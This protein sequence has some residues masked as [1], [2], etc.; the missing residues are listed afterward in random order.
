MDDL[1]PTLNVD[2][3]GHRLASVLADHARITADEFAGF[4]AAADAHGVL[5][6][7][8]SRSEG[9]R[10]RAV[11]RDAV[12][13]DAVFT[14]GLADALRALDAAGVRTLVLKGAHLALAHYPEPHLRPRSDA[15]LFIPEESRHAARLAL[16]D[17]GFSLVPHVRG[18]LILTQMHYT[19]DSNGFRHALD[20]HGR[21]LNPHAFRDLL[22]FDD[23]WARSRPIPAL[24]PSA[25]G[26]CDADAMLLAVTHPAAHH[27]GGVCLI[28]I[29][30]V[31]RIA[32]GL[33]PEGWREFVD[34]ACTSRVAR[35]ALASLTAASQLFRTVL[36]PAVLDTL[37]SDGRD[38]RAT[39]AYLLPA[40]RASRLW[41]ELRGLH[42][43]RTRARYLRQHLFPDRAYMR[44]AYGNH[45]I[46]LPWH[47][48]VRV[49]SGAV[50]W[51]VR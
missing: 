40:T 8:A 26:L 39:V 12:V 2:A 15:D 17:A 34:G 50:R 28:W 11:L 9:D 51:L 45:P 37:S 36:P 23:A 38:Q 16:E 33:P 29:V 19:R 25:R 48:F 1:F 49:A 14:A 4:E 3:A 44:E 46:L 43:W 42:G 31:D 27:S 32:A 41:S 21:A 5:P 22:S 24:G 30:D 35:V 47:Y 13:F 20:V 10:A 6:L 7:L 18:D